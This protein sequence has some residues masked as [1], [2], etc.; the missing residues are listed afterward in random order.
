ML[1][2]KSILCSCQSTD[3]NVTQI[4][5]LSSGYNGGWNT[6]SYQ[7]IPSPYRISS[8]DLAWGAFRGC[9]RWRGRCLREARSG[10]GADSPPPQDRQCH[11]GSSLFAAAPG[12]RPTPALPAF[13]NVLQ[14]V[15]TAHNCILGKAFHIELGMSSNQPGQVSGLSAEG[16]KRRDQGLTAACLLSTLCVCG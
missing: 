12:S 13:Q 4:S 5:T 11:C 8:R 9:D 1:T 2:L 6:E 15:W 16:I 7:R 14:V 3:A 10:A